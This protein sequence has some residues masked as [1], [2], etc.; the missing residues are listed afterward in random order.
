MMN[1][2]EDY[3]IKE[4]GTLY[5]Y[6][7]NERLNKP[8][9]DAHNYFLKG[10]C[11]A[12]LLHKNKSSRGKHAGRRTR[13]SIP[14]EAA[15][16]DDMFTMIKDAFLRND[17][18]RHVIKVSVNKLRKK[19]VLKLVHLCIRDIKVSTPNGKTLYHIILDTCRL[20]FLRTRED[21]A[22]SATRNIAFSYMNN[23]VDS[24]HLSKLCNAPGVGS[25]YPKEDVEFRVCYKFQPSIR[26][27]LLNYIKVAKTEIDDIPETCNCS[28]SPFKN[29][30]IGCVVTGDLKII[31]NRKLRNLM[32]KGVN[33]RECKNFPKQVMLK[34][35]KKDIDE[36]IEK[37]CKSGKLDPKA[38]EDWKKEL[39]RRLDES[40]DQTMFTKY[41]ATVTDK[42][43]VKDYIEELQKEYVLVPTDKAASNISVVCKKYYLEVLRDELENTP[44]YERVD[45][46]SE[47][48]IRQHEEEMYDGP[49]DDETR[50]LP[51]VYWLPKQHKTPPKSR[52]VVSGKYCTM[53]PLAKTLSKALKTVQKCVKYKFDFEFKFKKSSAFWVIDNAVNVHNSMNVINQ[54]HGAKSVNTF[55]FSTLYTMIP[56]DKLIERM[57][58][59]VEMAFK[60]SKKP[61][62]RINKSTATWAAKL[63]AKTKLTYYTVDGLMEDIKVL[64]DNIYIQHAGKIYRQII[65]IPI[66]SDCSQDLANLFLSSY[67][68]EYV[69]GLINDGRDDDAE[70]LSFVY[71]YID[72][73]ITMNDVGFLDR[74][75]KDI[76]P[77]EMVLNKTNTLDDKATFL[78]LDITI[79]NNKFTTTVYDKR[80]DFGFKVISLPHYGSN[81]PKSSLSGV[82]VSQ[83]HRMFRANST[84][85]GF[86]VNIK[87]LFDKLCDKLCGQGFNKGHVSLLSKFENKNFLD[88]IYKYWEIIDFKEFS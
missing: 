50:K 35:L 64:L 46:S 77:S 18:F 57:R 75:Y 86:I 54:V 51:Y 69:Y 1:A 63:P 52:F 28:S 34:F 78:D 83:I 68:Q 31:K 2:R 17:N 3:W 43:S 58:L 76:Y 22:R 37:S 5:P 80:N 16:A 49:I 67:E 19:E 41:P 33:F 71:R 8:Y 7:L 66:G 39:C 60:V 48:I 44:S 20:C 24:L 6:G 88:I 84:I 79:V 85:N 53:K 4:L 26:H 82:V 36:H 61:Y 11:I 56:H 9:I 42:D 65:G 45:R 40:V 87:S 47:D 74:M 12:Q 30:V 10:K 23:N 72:D 55:D 29:N 25:L 13:D 15:T 73:L 14:G 21:A 38:F 81:V 62:L 59:V 70:F 27:A 32:M